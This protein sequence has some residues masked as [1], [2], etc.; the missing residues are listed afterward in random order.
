MKRRHG[1]RQWDKL[2]EFCLIGRRNNHVGEKTIDSINILEFEL[3]V[4]ND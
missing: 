4:F 3:S 2:G 1:Q